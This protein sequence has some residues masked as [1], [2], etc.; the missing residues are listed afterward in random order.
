MVDC[1]CVDSVLVDC[2][3]VD[4]FAFF[5]GYESSISAFDSIATQQVVGS[6]VLSGQ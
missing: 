2:C 6:N 3:L 4:C 1:V 5:E